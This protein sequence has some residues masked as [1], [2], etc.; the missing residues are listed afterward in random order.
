[1]SRRLEDGAIAP[2]TGP[3]NLIKHL[4]GICLHKSL[5]LIPTRPALSCHSFIPSDDSWS[6]QALFLTG[7]PFNILFILMSTEVV[8]SCLMYTAQWRPSCEPCRCVSSYEYVGRTEEG[9][10]NSQVRAVLWLQCPV[11]GHTVSSPPFE[12]GNMSMFMDTT[13]CCNRKR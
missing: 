5:H 13:A 10:K 2:L 9:C 4:L 3:H 11:A 1:M 6:F 7:Q 12:R 8:S